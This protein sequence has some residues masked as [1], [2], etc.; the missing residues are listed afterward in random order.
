[1]ARRQMHLQRRGNRWFLRV[2]VPAELRPVIGKSEIIRALKTGDRALADVRCREARVEV[3]KLFADARMRL[4]ARD[5][6][7]RPLPINPLPKLDHLP[8]ATPSPAVL[9]NMAARFFAERSADTYSRVLRDGVSDEAADMAGADAAMLASEEGAADV[10]HALYGVLARAGVRL[11]PQSDAYRLL[12]DLI[13]R[14]MVEDAARAEARYRGAIAEPTFDPAFANV[15]P[16]APTAP[17][18]P[19]RP[20]GLTLRELIEK[21][22]ND[23]GRGVNERTKIGY[24]VIFRAVSEVIGPDRDVRTISREDCRRVRDVIVNLPPNATKRF[25]N[26]SLEQAAEHAKAKGLPV[27]APKNVTN[28]LVNM[29]ALFNW[30]TVEGFMDSNPAKGLRVAGGGLKKGSR[31]P[32]TLDQLRLIFN[33]PLYRGCMDDE[34]GYATPGPN[35]I[36][37]GRFF[38]PLLSLFHGL[39]LGEAVQLHTS[40]VEVRD[41]VPVMIVREDP[42]GVGE[43]GT[44]R[45][46]KTEAAARVIPLHPEMQKMGFLVLVEKQRAAGQVRLFPEMPAGALGYYSDPAQKWFGRFLIKAGAARPRTSFHSFR[47]CFRDALR[48]AGVRVAAVRALGGWVGADTSGVDEHYGAG[49]RPSSLAAELAKVAYPG[50]DLKHLHVT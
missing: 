34:D 18:D 49:L 6:A 22:E 43:E 41:G 14:A 10:D 11:D 37:R 27:I 13:R 36:R 20:A 50:L 48:E 24:R 12:R 3:D 33:A 35:V 28:Y 15:Q 29:A 42:D 31:E 5:G 4:Q 25:P 16:V 44:R 45:H 23:P 21:Y 7:I 9:H 8:V 32:F 26:L 2:R 47:H 30:A 40:D 46:L 38:V 39:R 1:M 19:A 17:A